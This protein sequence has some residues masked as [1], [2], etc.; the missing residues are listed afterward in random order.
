MEGSERPAGMETNGGMQGR[1]A[2]VQNFLAMNKKYFESGQLVFVKERLC[3]IPEDRFSML[4][5]LKFKSPGA[6][7]ALSIFFGTIGVDR[8][9]LGD[10]GLGLGKLFTGGGC[11]VWA[12][13]DWFLIRKAA[14]RKN[15]EKLMAALL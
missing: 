8:F 11:G 15:Y 9:Y 2:R 4:G 6:A 1:E 7:L 12:F 10:T 13:V 14:R 5:A 3:A